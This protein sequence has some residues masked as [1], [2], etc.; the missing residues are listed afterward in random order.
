M[1][2]YEC[3]L[4]GMKDKPEEK[5]ERGGKGGGNERFISKM[6]MRERGGEGKGREGEREGRGKKREGRER[7]RE[8]ER[9]STS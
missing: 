4:L 7:E 3:S 2:H 5:R 1:L 6:C 8:R 9:I